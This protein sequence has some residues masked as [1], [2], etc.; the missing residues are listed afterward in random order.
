MDS[1]SLIVD[2]N[3]KHV[4]GHY[5]CFEEA[6]KFAQALNLKTRKEWRAYCKSTDDVICIPSYIPKHPD[7]IYKNYGWMG[8]KNWLG[9]E[10]LMMG[11]GIQDEQT[12]KH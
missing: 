2:L 8:W 9:T 5:L 7:G 10:T 3:K 6:R 11:N 4:K 1:E 12:T